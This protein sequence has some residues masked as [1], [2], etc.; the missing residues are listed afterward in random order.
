MLLDV[1]VVTAYSTM[2][3]GLQKC[4]EHGIEFDKVG[5]EWVGLINTL[6]IHEQKG[7]DRNVKNGK[8]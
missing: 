4:T 7:R 2:Q 8:Q 5:N 3:I 1:I 6:A